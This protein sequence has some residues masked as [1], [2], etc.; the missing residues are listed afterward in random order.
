MRLGLE[1]RVKKTDA[2]V[3]DCMMHH[4]VLL[5]RMDTLYRMCTSVHETSVPEQRNQLGNAAATSDC[6]YQCGVRGQ[7]VESSY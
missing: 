4:S 1:A 5:V 6:A 7:I 3:V 2:K